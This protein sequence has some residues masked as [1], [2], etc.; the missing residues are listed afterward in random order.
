VVV[1]LFGIFK[2][3]SCKTY[4]A[5]ETNSCWEKKYTCNVYNYNKQVASNKSGLL[6]KIILQSTQTFQ[7][8]LNGNHLQKKLRCQAKWLEFG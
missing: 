8:N 5:A 7:L 4:L 6:L 1:A 2:N 3:L